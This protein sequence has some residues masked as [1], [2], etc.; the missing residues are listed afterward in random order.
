MSK[1]EAL[2]RFELLMAQGYV[3]GVKDSKGITRWA[4]KEE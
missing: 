1:E 3:E 2:R 4:F